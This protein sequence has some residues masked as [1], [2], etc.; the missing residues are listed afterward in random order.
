MAKNVQ[1]DEI[2][3]EQSDIPYSVT[4]DVNEIVSFLKRPEPTVIF[5]TYQ[6]SDLIAK[7][8]KKVPNHMFDLSIADE[9]HRCTGKAN[10]EFTT[11]LDDEKIRVKKLFGTQHLN[12][13]N[14]YQKSSTG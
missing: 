13:K 14:L 9:A 6:S 11:I 4:W 5:S 1:E 3:L 10:S 7:A 12:Y 2:I 8:Q